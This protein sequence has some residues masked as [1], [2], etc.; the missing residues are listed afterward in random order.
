[1]TEPHCGDSCLP[2]F[3]WSAETG[4]WMEIPEQGNS[5][6]F[7]DTL[8]RLFMWTA[9]LIWTVVSNL[10]R[11]AEWTLGAVGGQS[12]RVLSWIYDRMPGPAWVVLFAAIFISVLKPTR[13]EYLTQIFK[14]GLIAFL[15]VSLCGVLVTAAKAD[16]SAGAEPGQVALSPSWTVEQVTGVTDLVVRPVSEASATALDRETETARPDSQDSPLSCRRYIAQLRNLHET[17]W[18]GMQTLSVAADRIWGEAYYRKWSEMVAGEHGEHVGCRIAEGFRG[19]SASDQARLTC[20][21]TNAAPATCKTWV[22]NVDTASDIPVRRQMR[23]VSGSGYRLEPPGD[24]LWIW[25]RPSDAWQAARMFVPWILCQPPQG[26]NMPWTMREEAEEWQSVQN[27]NNEAYTKSLLAGS[28]P[29]GTTNSGACWKWWNWP[30]GSEIPEPGDEQCID[31]G[32]W[33]VCNEL[34]DSSGLTVQGLAWSGVKLAGAKVLKFAGKVGGYISAGATIAGAAGFGI[35]GS[36]VSFGAG[37]LGD[38]ISESEKRKIAEK[39]SNSIF[40][41]FIGYLGGAGEERPES[42]RYDPTN[43]HEIWRFRPDQNSTNLS[44]VAAIS[45]TPDRA[46]SQAGLALAAAIIYGLAVLLIIAMGAWGVLLLVGTATFAPFAFFTMGISGR[47]Q[48]FAKSVWHYGKLSLKYILGANFALIGLVICV[49]LLPGFISAGDEQVSMVV[50]GVAGWMMFWLFRKNGKGRQAMA[51]QSFDVKQRMRRMR[52][53]AMSPAKTAKERAA[54]PLR[55][56]SP[57]DTSVMLSVAE[58][59]RRNGALPDGWEGDPESW[60]GVEFS[61]SRVRSVDLSGVGLYAVPESLRRLQALESLNLSGNTGLYY[62]PAFLA[63]LKL[64][65]TV[66]LTG[67]SSFGVMTS[68]PP[69]PK[70][71]E[72]SYLLKLRTSGTSLDYEDIEP[73][74]QHLIQR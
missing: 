50:F 64:L 15:G 14:R 2:I 48:G 4:T 33:R 61:G 32:Q 28:R 37:L 3:R 70:E 54:A 44:S 65:R 21:A 63:D 16:V 74:L 66:D 25:Q 59:L 58:E 17:D 1:M 43:S 6:Q 40:G 18:T 47:T 30:D 56:A 24:P 62:L 23:A 10:I 69:V 45:G 71:L 46:L 29:T 13:K 72:N 26:Q 20:E 53:L 51:Q 27:T 9:G 11:F 5:N 19:T 12:D 38:K 73:S 57:R 52:S 34:G 39:V 41:Y 49:S 7:G 55:R 36:I 60:P 31:H 68:P 8:A 35:V 67:C 42:T 22:E